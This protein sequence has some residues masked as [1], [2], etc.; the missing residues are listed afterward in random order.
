MM[1]KFHLHNLNFIQLDNFPDDSFLI[2]HLIV[3]FCPFHEWQSRQSY[4]WKQ[5]LPIVIPNKIR[6]DREAFE[7]AIRIS[8]DLSVTIQN[9]LTYVLRRMM[10]EG[11]EP[12]RP[13]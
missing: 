11:Y 1:G 8:H 13:K 7:E 2:R 12:F 9:K 10:T 5:K 4:L 6:P 3:N